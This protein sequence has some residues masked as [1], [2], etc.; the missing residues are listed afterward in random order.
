[1]VWN[2]AREL[3]FNPKNN[4]K[5]FEK[6]R[7][8]TILIIEHDYSDNNVKN[9]FKGMGELKARKQVRIIELFRRKGTVAW[10]KI[11][12]VSRREEDKYEVYLEVIN[13]G[14]WSWLDEKVWVKGKTKLRMIPK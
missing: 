6:N 7:H 4:G 12:T 1:M 14:N 2:H 13:E 3:E 5:L 9:W 10:T 8:L 11:M